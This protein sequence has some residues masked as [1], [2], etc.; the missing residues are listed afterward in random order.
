MTSVPASR[1]RGGSAPP[2]PGRLHAI[3]LESDAGCKAG[4]EARPDRVDPPLGGG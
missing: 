3:V 4:I 1:V 2:A